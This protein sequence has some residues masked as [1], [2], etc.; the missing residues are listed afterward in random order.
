M[1]NIVCNGD[2]N[3]FILGTIFAYN[4]TLLFLF[5]VTSDYREILTIHFY[6]ALQNK[7]FKV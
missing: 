2:E 7:A 1:I 4:I 6:S 3:S 5:Y